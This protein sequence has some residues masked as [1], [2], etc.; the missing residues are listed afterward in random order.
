M[1]RPLFVLQDIVLS[2]DSEVKAKIHKLLDGSEPLI[3]E[4]LDIFSLILNEVKKIDMAS[5]L[6]RELSVLGVRVY[7]DAKAIFMLINNGY[8]LQS[9]MIERDM[10]E[11]R[12]LT[13]YFVH[14]EEKVE[15]WRKART[16]KERR[17]FEISKIKEHTP[18]GK[19]WKELFDHFSGYLHPNNLGG[20]VYARE[21]EYFGY[22][23]YLGGIF[24]PSAIR[25]EF[26]I[27]FSLLSNIVGSYIDWYGDRLKFPKEI[28]ERFEK[29]NSASDIFCGE[30]NK[31]TDILEAEF[32]KQIDE[33]RLSRDQI[34]ETWRILDQM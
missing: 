10:V 6:D 13:S 29:V 34:I 5:E 21:K 26:Q 28:S 11:I 24:T 2:N 8:I 14:N 27:A 4:C 25:H 30:L 1:P 19:E 9:M 17:R 12:V 33:K 16:I 7:N 15:E 32:R 20:V 22:N 18:E 3:Q 31:K 23:L